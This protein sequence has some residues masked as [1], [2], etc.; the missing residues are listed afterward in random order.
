MQH[1]KKKKKF[2]IKDDLEESVSLFFGFQKGTVEN[3]LKKKNP[4]IVWMELWGGKQL[5]R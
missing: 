1:E 4:T 5:K 3:C 2:F